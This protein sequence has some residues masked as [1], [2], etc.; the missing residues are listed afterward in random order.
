MVMVPPNPLERH[1]TAR[2]EVERGIPRVMGL[3][4]QS[5]ASRLRA[6]HSN[7]RLDLVS[8]HCI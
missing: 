1:G 6:V 4:V 7:G 8:V 5:G 2:L 3:G